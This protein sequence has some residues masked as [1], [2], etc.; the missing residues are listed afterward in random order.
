MP[1]VFPGLACDTC[2]SD[3]DTEKELFANV[4]PGHDTTT[5]PGFELICGSV[6]FGGEKYTGVDL[7]TA[8]CGLRLYSNCRLTLVSFPRTGYSRCHARSCWYAEGD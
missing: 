8:L 5:L 3:D 7:I 4:V 6:V 2:G 1:T